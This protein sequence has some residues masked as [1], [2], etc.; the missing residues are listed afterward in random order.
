MASRDGTASRDPEPAGILAPAPLLALGVFAIGAVAHLIIPVPVLPSPIQLVAGA[1]LLAV[2]AGILGHGF[3][4]M[5]G[6]EKSP[7]H[8]D[9]PD[10][11][12]TEGLFAYSRNP[13]YIGVIV[14]YL[15]LTAFLNSGWPL[16]PLVGLVWYFDR[17]ARREEDYLEAR[18]GEE[19]ERYCDEVDRWL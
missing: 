19:F 17:V 4:T 1:V 11:L 8:H 2:G 6:I 5:R 16:V 14:A 10:E 15:G 3:L 18:F 13:L 12:L 7:A 9:E